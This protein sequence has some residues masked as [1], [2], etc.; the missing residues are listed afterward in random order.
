MENI[1]QSYSFSEIV[2][3]NDQEL[4]KIEKYRK[5]KLSNTPR[6]LIFAGLVTLGVLTA[7]L[8][9]L[10][11]IAGVVALAATA[12][13]GV[14]GFFG[15]R[16]LKSMDVVIRQKTKN[17]RIK[18]MREEAKKNA[19][20]Q[21]DNQVL[22]NEERLGDARVA[23]DKMGA[24]IENLK[25]KVN[26]ANKGKPTY[27]KKIAVIERL[28]S[29]YHQVINNLD[30]AARANKLFEEKVQEY[31]DMDAFSQVASEAMELFENTAGHKLEDM[32][33]L[34]AFN[35]IDH[36]FSTALI[37]IENSARDMVID[38]ED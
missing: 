32:L 24:S 5:E 29:A 23:R 22:L 37:S 33:S 34:E 26:P 7:G 12:V 20:A 19:T 14:G 25:S 1:K 36:E 28:E 15:L 3:N 4:A 11:I 17:Q 30:K 13:V 8:F 2:N 35:S 31:K 10:Q 16:W 27:E 21:L 9:A 6:N 18:L 38:E